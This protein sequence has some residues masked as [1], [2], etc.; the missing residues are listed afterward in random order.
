MNVRISANCPGDYGWSDWDYSSTGGTTSLIIALDH[1]RQKHNL[2]IAVFALLSTPPTL[3]A[4]WKAS[5]ATR[6]QIDARKV[7]FA[8][9]T[10]LNAA[11]KWPSYFMFLLL[12]GLIVAVVMVV[13]ATLTT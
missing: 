2:A 9:L 8:L 1:H 6:L 10:D 13:G 7:M 3:C 5:R 12:L 4:A 11:L